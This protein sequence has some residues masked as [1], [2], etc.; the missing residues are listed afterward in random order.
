MDTVQENQEDTAQSG[1][2]G[3]NVGNAGG[4]CFREIKA[5]M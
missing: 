2:E 1:R 4:Y 5:T 3:Y